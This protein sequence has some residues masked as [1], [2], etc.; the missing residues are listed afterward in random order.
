MTVSPP[1]PPP[2]APNVSAAMA[3]VKARGLRLSAAR[4]LVIAALGAADRP[5]T[6]DTIAGGIGGRLPRSDLASVYRNLETLEQ[7]GVV[8]HVHAGHGP[9][10]YALT[11]PGSRDYLACEA[12]GRLEAVDPAQLEPVR[13]AV[14]ECSGFEPRF[15]HFPIT[16]LCP[17]CASQARPASAPSSLAARTAPRSA[18]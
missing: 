2:E 9:G 12:C 5:V 15:S 13:R 8:C 4:R 18:G 14:R 11:A 6:A 7:A 17:R 10:L 1:G 3:A 16:G